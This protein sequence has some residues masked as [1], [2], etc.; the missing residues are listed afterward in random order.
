MNQ[1]RYWLRG[2]IGATLATVILLWAYIAYNSIPRGYWS[3]G[4]VENIQCDFFTFIKSDLW[5]ITAIFVVPPLI[6]G[7]ILG[8]I[9]G[10]IRAK[11]NAEPGL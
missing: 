4:L 9:Y 10:K 7:M 5:I 11:R 3:C 2:G 8:W 1:K 6:I